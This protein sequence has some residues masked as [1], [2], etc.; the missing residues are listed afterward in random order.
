MRARWFAFAAHIVGVVAAAAFGFDIP[1]L[2]VGIILGLELLLGAFLA[3]RPPSPESGGSKL[4]L[5]MSLD[6]A[7]LTGLLMLT[8]GPHNPFSVVYMVHVAIAAAA[9][10]TR[11]AAL[12][13]AG[14]LA[15]SSLLFVHYR[16]LLPR[17]SAPDGAAE[18]RE[19]GHAGH[20]GHAAADDTEAEAHASPH[21]GM[22]MQLHVRGM[23]LGYIAAG[24][25][26]V[27]FVAEL[28]SKLR[29]QQ[30]L[31]TESREAAARAERLSSLATLS[32]GAAHELATPLASIAVAAGELE[33]QL[34][35]DNNLATDV[36]TIRSQVERCR[37]I[38]E[39]MAVEGGQPVAGALRQLTP[40]ALLDEALA[41]LSDTERVLRN[42]EP[43]AE[44]ARIRSAG[45]SLAGGI[46]NLIDNA[47]RASGAPVHVG[48]SAERTAED[49][50]PA[51]LVF[52]IRDE[53]PGLDRSELKRVGE[54]FYTTRP[55]GTGTGLGVFVARRVAEQL[56]GSLEFESVVGAGTCA[57]LRVPLAED[58]PERGK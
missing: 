46:R 44:T 3:L 11:R 47:L 57:R 39:R 31:L 33:A 58:D 8:G 19:D 26:V 41:E 10:P 16:P 6:G 34:S 54:P 42:I 49:N 4:A 30:V 13:V 18:H 22:S 17:A 38:L 24:A 23:W 12:V 51:M 9:L 40:A 50:K 55:P 2:G 20:T 29:A 21:G 5:A 1:W 15:M 32:A 53:G 7:I 45:T 37:R 36:Q 48:V 27:W 52:S 35:A 25:V 28:R 43:A 56:G 14:T